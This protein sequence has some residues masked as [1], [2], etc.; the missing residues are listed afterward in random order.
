[1]NVYE[2]DEDIV[3]SFDDLISSAMPVKETHDGEEV[4]VYR[5]GPDDRSPHISCN[6]A[7]DKCASLLVIASYGPSLSIH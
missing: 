6:V 7:K 1:M 2:D 4:T 5:L 3:I